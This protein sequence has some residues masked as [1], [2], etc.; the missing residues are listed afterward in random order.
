ME[1][2]VLNTVIHIINI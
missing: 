1:Y 2:Y